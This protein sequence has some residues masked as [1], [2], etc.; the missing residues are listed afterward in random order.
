MVDDIYKTTRKCE[1][2]GLPIFTDYCDCYIHVKQFR[3]IFTPPISISP[4]RRSRSHE[5]LLLEPP[6]NETD[7]KAAYHKLCL[8]HHPDKGGCA[9]KFIEINDAYNE[10]IC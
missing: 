5:I 10:L 7:I 6:V 9:E 1:Y 3:N 4:I 8:L 2:T